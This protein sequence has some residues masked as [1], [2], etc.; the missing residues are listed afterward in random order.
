MDDDKDLPA[1]FENVYRI[2]CNLTP[3]NDKGLRPSLAQNFS[4]Y[5][6]HIVGSENT[7]S[8]GGMDDKRAKLSRVLEKD[9]EMV[10]DI[11]KCLA[12]QK[13]EEEERLND[14]VMAL[15]VSLISGHS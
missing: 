5:I 6:G 14:V 9:G 11:L 15:S 12:Q 8:H 7:D 13:Q 2:I 3:M 10:F 4:K 1:G